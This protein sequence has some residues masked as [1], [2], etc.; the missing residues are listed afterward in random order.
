M[1]SNPKIERIITAGENFIYVV[2]VVFLFTSSALLIYD[3]ARTLYH[4]AQKSFGIIQIIEIIA[5]TLLL[6]MIIEILT[7]VRI[8][9]KNHVLSAEPFLIVG[10]IASIRR[11]L[12]ISVETAYV[13]EHFNN[14]M[15]EIG[16]LTI[17]IF[18][19]IISMVLLRKHNLK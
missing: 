15:I 18:V 3:E 7:T 17:L 19:F 11:I 6:L 2:I 9:L 12:I 14:F 1:Q 8:S 13:Y 5:K 4:F 10:L 16:V